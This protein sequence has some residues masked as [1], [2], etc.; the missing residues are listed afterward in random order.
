MAAEISEAEITSLLEL[1]LSGQGQRAA[2]FLGLLQD[3]FK[4]HVI[5]HVSFGQQI[6]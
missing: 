1:N 5:F 2:D 4:G 6:P 3:G